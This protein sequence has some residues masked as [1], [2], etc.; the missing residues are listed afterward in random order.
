M[1]PIGTGTGVGPDELTVGV[2]IPYMVKYSV[3]II[4]SSVTKNPVDGLSFV[5]AESEVVVAFP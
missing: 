4:S 5:V 1:E 2:H 3:V